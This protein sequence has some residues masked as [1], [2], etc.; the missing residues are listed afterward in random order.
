MNLNNI[1]P[2]YFVGL[3]MVLSNHPQTFRENPVTFE[4]NSKNADNGCNILW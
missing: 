2:H 3:N 1:L 4:N